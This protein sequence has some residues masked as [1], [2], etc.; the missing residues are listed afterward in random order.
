MR[1]IVKVIALT[2]LL[3]MFLTFA[4]ACDIGVLIGG[5]IGGNSDNGDNNDNGD[6]DENQDGVNN[7]DVGNDEIEDETPAGPSQTAATLTALY[8]DSYRVS[9]FKSDVFEYEVS[10]DVAYG[11]G[12]VTYRAASSAAKVESTVDIGRVEIK[13]TSGDGMTTNTYKIKFVPGE[14]DTSK[15]EIV[16]KDGVDAVV[17]YVIDD[18][19][20]STADY[21]KEF[22]EKYDYLN[23]SFAIQGDKFATLYTVPANDGKT[24]YEI[25][26]KGQ[27]SFYQTEAQ[28]TYTEYWK[29]LIET[30]LANGNKVEILGHSYS[31]AA[32]GNND[33]G[34]TQTVLKGDKTP[35]TA[36]FPV[37]SSSAQ[38]YGTQ[39][40]LS[41]YFGEYFNSQTTLPY[42]IAGTGMYSNTK[43]PE[44]YMYY[45]YNNIMKPGV[46]NDTVISARN[47][48]VVTDSSRN[49]LPRYVITA[50]KYKD[51]AYRINTPGYMINR[52]NGGAN[53][54]DTYLWTDYIDEAINNGG[55]ASFC[56]HYIV[57]DGSNYTKHD[58]SAS[59]ADALFGYTADKN[60]WV[61]TYT[62][63]ALYYAEWSTSTLNTEYDADNN[64]ITVSITDEENDEVFNMALTA[65]IT[66][67]KTWE[68]AFAGA[69]ELEIHENEDG[70]KFVYVNVV[71]DAPAATVISAIAK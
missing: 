15:N 13:V 11:Q 24:Y 66:I 69:E 71:P 34:G 49:Q 21:A 36:D 48:F 45:L 59:Q 38:I 25:N 20:E 19:I 33:D 54:S 53:A 18:G 37:G 70:S 3:S 16:N 63:A 35:Y 5:I 22:M 2:L 58:I 14:L 60:V 12:N 9:G 23:L 44:S 8:V 7:G 17:S 47:C 39:Q 41:K 29:N 43:D 62:E 52:S 67:P 51:L 65:K 10:Y 31:H 57:P 50:E 46:E 26:N 56:I 61:A 55:W 6:G 40:I 28:E 4:T 30:A 42:I 64:E 32:W 27:Y 1:K 68:S